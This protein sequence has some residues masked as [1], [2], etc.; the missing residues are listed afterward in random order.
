MLRHGSSGKFVILD[1]PTFELMT[2]P[3]I[4]PR[5]TRTYG[6]D[7][8][9]P[10]SSNRGES[11]STA[12]FG[13]GGFTGTAMWID[14]GKNRVIVFLSNRLHPDGKGSVNRLAGEIATLVG[15]SVSETAD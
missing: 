11:L 9:S 5:G 3:R 2:S 12:A 15:N 10:Y 7:H 4:V 6:W 1:E 14:P 8:Q 13:H